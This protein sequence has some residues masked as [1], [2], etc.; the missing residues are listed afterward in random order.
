MNLVHLPTFVRIT[1]PAKKDLQGATVVI[2][3]PIKSMKGKDHVTALCDLTAPRKMGGADYVIR[4]RQAHR[5]SQ[6][7][8][9]DSESD[10]WIDLDTVSDEVI[11]CLFLNPDL[12]G[13]IMGVEI[14]SRIAHA[15]LRY[16]PSATSPVNVVHEHV[17][18]MVK[19]DSRILTAMSRIEDAWGRN[20]LDRNIDVYDIL[21]ME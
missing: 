2:R 14:G 18:H 4:T 11:E 6:V 17:V 9:M 16:F 5:R 21:Q 3:P 12:I 13:H 1:S 8:E 19:A 7:Y 15:I 20:W 10:V